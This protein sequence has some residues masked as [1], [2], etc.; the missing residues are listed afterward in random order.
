MSWARFTVWALV[1][2]VAIGAVTL[3]ADAL[4][5]DDSERV[6]ELADLLDEGN[7]DALLAWVDTER[8]DVVV[9]ADGRT[10]RFGPDDDV[11]SPI[12][13]AL[14]PFA[15]RHELV[16]RNVVVEGDRAD[17]ALRVR[18][19]GEVHD[20]LLGLRR[21]GQSWLVTEVRRLD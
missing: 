3:A 16:Q 8:A 7:P 18:A 13:A 10:R 14:A 4:V 2:T 15:E 20:V 21:D 19:S 5:V 11:A 9:R 6:G 17:V 1:A 12:R